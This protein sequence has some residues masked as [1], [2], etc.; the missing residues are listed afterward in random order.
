MFTALLDAMGGG[1][2]LARFLEAAVME[3]R[4]DSPS[5]DW[6]RLGQLMRAELGWDHY[7]ASPPHRREAAT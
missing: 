7:P 5:V 1:G 3:A 4:M 6:I 2:A